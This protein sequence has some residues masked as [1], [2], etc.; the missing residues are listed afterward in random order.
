MIGGRL[1]RRIRPFVLATAA[2]VLGVP[3][4]A[5]PPDDTG[6]AFAVEEIDDGWVVTPD[7]RIT[8]VDDD[9]TAGFGV[10]GG[11]QLDRRLL[12]GAGAYWLAGDHTDL[13]YFG[14]VIE[15]STKTGGRFDVSI[16]A[17]VGIG[18]AT[19]YVPFGDRFD[20]TFGDFGDFRDLRGIEASSFPPRGGRR[21]GRGRDHRFG[22]GFGG[23]YDE[24]TMAEPHVSFL[25][26][27]TDWL[28]LT[29]GVGYRATNSDFGDGTTLNGASFRFGVRFGPS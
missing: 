7:F 27:A 18:S 20:T 4:I 5:Q 14:P 19:K 15:W 3:A 16:G 12:I 13:S 1:K 6:R 21:F 22:R 24:F 11:Y 26:R 10:Y 9:L 8:E 25:A 2:T 17:L 28:G 29:L 23:L